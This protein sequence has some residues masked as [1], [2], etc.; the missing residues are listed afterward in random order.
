MPLFYGMERVIRLRQK[1]ETMSMNDAE[2]HD[3]LESIHADLAIIASG[4]LRRSERHVSLH[5]HDLVGEAVMRV[6][7]AKALAFE[8]ESH[9]KALIARTMRRVLV[10]LARKRHAH[11]RSG[12]KVT[13]VTDLHK[14]PNGGMDLVKLDSALLRLKALD[15]ERAEIVTL[16]YFG[17]MSVD[18]VAEVLGCSASSVT[19]SW[20]TA[21][22]WLKDALKSDLA[23]VI[24]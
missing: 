3:P 11:K 10:D 23:N 18:E 21:R 12:Q 20:R 9:L 22:S 1:G 13:L 4:L 2:A 5:T 8:S 7:G 16:R 24:Q 19:R 17:G 6:L 14:M 15:A